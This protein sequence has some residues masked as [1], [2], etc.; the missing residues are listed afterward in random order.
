MPIYEYVC[1]ACGDERE[2]LQKLSDPLL[3]RCPVCGA[4]AFVKKVSLPS[5]RLKGAG[6]YATDFKDKPKPAAADG[7]AAEAK[8][9]GSA[10][11]EGS[12]PAGASAPAKDTKPAPVAKPAP[13]P[14]TP[15]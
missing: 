8:P 9:A 3:T 7:A 13:A 2:V 5:F 14:A 11:T 15:D 6:W 1:G 12:A 4:Q 10:A